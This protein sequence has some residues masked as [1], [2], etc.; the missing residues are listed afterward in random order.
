M[1]ASAALAESTA[2]V[3]DIGR[4]G[5]WQKNDKELLTTRL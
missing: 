3:R 1:I 2:L 5:K 4:M